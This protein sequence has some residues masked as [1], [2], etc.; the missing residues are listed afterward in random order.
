MSKNRFFRLFSDRPKSI[1]FYR[2]LCVDHEYVIL[3][4]GRDRELEIQGNIEKYE[5]SIFFVFGGVFEQN[6]RSI[7]PNLDIQTY[8]TEKKS[9]YRKYRK[10]KMA[11][12]DIYHTY[13]ISSYSTHQSE[14][15]E[16]C[17][18]I[19]IRHFEFSIFRSFRL[20]SVKYV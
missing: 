4:W 17:F 13:H 9:K 6:I 5:K 20:F 2:V 16:P 15:N 12:I 18:V 3:R 1:S 14:S 7:M 19:D 8:L 11:D 10:F